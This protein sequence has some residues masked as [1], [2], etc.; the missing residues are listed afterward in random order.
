[1]RIASESLRTKSTKATSG[2]RPKRRTYEPFGVYL[3]VACC[4]DI[5]KLY[6]YNIQTYIHT[7][8]HTHT[9][10]EASLDGG[11]SVRVCASVS[12]CV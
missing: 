9:H 7:Y 1:M 12:V 5:H 6:I 11:V 2:K 3:S 8:I 10:S 4:R